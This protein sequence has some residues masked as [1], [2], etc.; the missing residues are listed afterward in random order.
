MYSSHL[1]II[2]IWDTFS[3]WWHFGLWRYTH[4]TSLHMVASFPLYIWVPND[5]LCDKTD[6]NWLVRGLPGMIYAL[7]LKKWF[8]I[9]VVITNRF[10]KWIMGLGQHN[11]LQ[12]SWSVWMLDRSVYNLWKSHR[13][14]CYT[15]STGCYRIFAGYYN[16]YGWWLLLYVVAIGDGEL[17]SNILKMD[18][19]LLFE[20]G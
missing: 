4:W 1:H 6:W 13:N 9:W 19:L 2:F 11:A 5:C 7:Y 10:H 8:S 12:A 3:H 17:V 15:S 14:I 20:E 18:P 16:G